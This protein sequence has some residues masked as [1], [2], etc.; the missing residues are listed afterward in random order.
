MIPLPR[1]L[2]AG[3]FC[4][5]A[6]CG[7]SRGPA[8]LDP[9]SGG[10]EVRP[11]TRYA[12]ANQCLALRARGN[13]QLLSADGEGYRASASQPAQAEAFRFKASALG[14]YLLYTRSG[15]LLAAAAPATTAAL[16]DASE[17]TVFTLRADGDGT[18]YPPT[19]V[20]DREPTPEQI[21]TYRGFRD[22]A[23]AATVFTFDAADGQRL[24]IDESGALT[25]AAASDS[26]AQRFVLEPVSGCADFPEAH[27]NTEGETFKGRLADGRVLGMADVHVHISATTFLGGAQSGNP[28]HPFGVTHALPD[29]AAEHGPR[30]ERDAVGAL[31]AGDMDGHAT[32]GWPTH[33]DWPARDALTHDA[34][35]WKWLE[36]AWKGGLRVVV[37]DVVDNQTLC[38]LQRNVSGTPARDCNEMNNAGQQ[39]G[40]MFAMQDY[41]DAQYG[42]PGRGFFRIVLSPAEARQVVENGQLAVVLGI[43]ISNLLNCTLTYNPLRTQQPFEETGSGA[44]EN[45]YSCAMTETGA[46]NEVLTQIRRL[47]GLGIRQVI[48]IHEFDNPFGGN[49]IFEGLVLNL[50]NRENSGGIPGDVVNNPFGVSETPTGEFWTTYTC[51]EED[52]EGFSGYLFGDSGG[53]VMQNLG[54]PPP[55]CVFTGQDGRPG[56]TTACYPPQGQCNARW[57]TP[58]GLYTYG[59]LMEFGMI[60]DVDHLE[61]GMKTQA[62]ELAEAQSPAYPFVSTHGTFGGMSNDQAMRILRNGGFIYPSLGNGPQ[63]IT[64]M[65]ELR[66]VHAAANTGRLFAFGFG[67]DTNGLSAQSGPRSEIAPGREVVYPYTLFDGG[68]FDTLPEFQAISGVT[69]F[70]PEERDAEGNGRSWS[71]D[72]DGSAHYGMM[73]DFVQEMRLE[74]NA[75][76]MRAL[77]NSAEGYL[78]TWEATEAS[79]AGIAQRGLVVPPGIL[80]AAPSD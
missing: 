14:D 70:Q 26:P 33:T 19:P 78:R 4:L 58:I 37:N 1:P 10:G 54:P 46:D 34:I 29:C 72:L 45:R 15:S 30:G 3:V 35:Y 67:T 21:Q 22:P 5:L 60:F 53:A 32:D 75:E 79:R 13:G 62:L 63:H 40:S 6:A 11:L 25:L 77:F 55:L 48:T 73:S 61:L 31:L 76:Q 57:L 49:G 8:R 51:P 2:L 52:A 71:L 80:R 42:G 64:L 9:V 68:L 12:A 38:E 50:G 18:A 24:A 56:G 39:V 41:I 43:E 47:H 20:F 44:S 36:R 28:F 66:S 17:A 7:D 16:A 27:D 69:F 65:E 23:I 59:K 74:G